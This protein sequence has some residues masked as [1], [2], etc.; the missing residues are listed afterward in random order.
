MFKPYSDIHSQFHKY[1]FTPSTWILSLASINIS[2][3]FY[4]DSFISRVI[5][6]LISW[7][8]LS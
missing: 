5:P 1:R 7:A 2:N 3:Q 4:S 6:D 8:K